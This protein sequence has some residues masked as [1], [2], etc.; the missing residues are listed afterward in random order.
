M[1]NNERLNLVQETVDCIRDTFNQNTE[2]DKLIR[3]CMA[4]VQNAIDGEYHDMEKVDVSEIERPHG[5]W[6]I[7]DSYPHRVYCNKCFKTYAQEK[8]E[9]WKDGSLPRKFCPNCGADMRKE[10]E[11]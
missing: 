11:V 7:T 5:E 10:E 1:N 2:S 9:V 8:W 3:N 6:L 4:L